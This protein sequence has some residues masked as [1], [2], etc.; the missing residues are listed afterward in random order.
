MAPHIILKET[1]LPHELKILKRGGTPEDWAEL[2]K[3]NAMNNVP[4]LVT[5]EGYCVSEVTAVLQYLNHKAGGKLFPTEGKDRFK[6]FEWLNFIASELHKGF[7]PLFGAEAYASDENCFGSIKA[8]AREM[9]AKKLVVT[10][11]RFEGPDY[12]VAGRFTI[13]DAYL[14]VVLGWS[15]YVKMDLAP[16]PKLNAFVTKTA[17]RP[18]VVAAMT[19]EGLLR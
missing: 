8:K 10:E 5:D 17:S 3:L 9:M 7:S 2:G 11:N 16:Y 12:P 18:S 1:K 14:F 6:A 19:E 4:T 13:V 15:K